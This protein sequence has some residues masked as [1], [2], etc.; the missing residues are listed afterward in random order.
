MS[1][2][3]VERTYERERML[4]AATYVGLDSL[5]DQYSSLFDQSGED[6]F[7]LSLPW[8]RNLERTVLGPDEVVRVI[9]VERRESGKVPAA[10][11][12]VK[13][14]RLSNRFLSQ[15]TVESLATYYTSYFAPV[16]A[17][18]CENVDEITK[19][20]AVKLAESKPRWDVLNIRPVDLLLASVNGLY[21]A[22]NELGFRTQT[23]FCFGN[24]YLKVGSRSYSEYF[25]DLP[26]VIRKN[27]P[28]YRRRLEKNARVRIKLFTTLEDLEIAIRDYELVYNSSWRDSEAYPN[29]VRG[30]VR[31]AAEQGWLRMGLF[32]ID[33]EP[34]AAQLWLVQGRVA[35]IYKVCYAEE[36][37]KS[38]VGS[39]LTAHM[40]EYALDTDRVE[41]V[42]YLSG[43]DDYKA[44]WMSDRRERWGIMAFNPATIMGN[45]STVKH[46]GGKYLKGK[47]ALAH[48]LMA[49][50]KGLPAGEGTNRRQ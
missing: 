6:S 36:F 8:F 30:L 3:P 27:I 41:E 1:K 16:I 9:G 15:L 49:S 48:D 47:L 25:K 19:L 28:Y 32:Y 38:S 39:V 20:L 2:I 5:P 24:W 35:S 17:R 21:T 11:L 31:I 33:D 26:S 44:N 7:F 23:Y 14:S 50:F 34:A 40:L 22:L 29:F 13:N 18:D 46:I 10:A 37:A 4:H 43:D 42:D 12:V 45:I